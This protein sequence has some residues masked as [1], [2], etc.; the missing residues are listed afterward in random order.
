MNKDRKSFQRDVWL[1]TSVVHQK[2][3]APNGPLVVHQDPH[4]DDHCLHFLNF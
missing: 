3:K 2:E 4:Q 1:D